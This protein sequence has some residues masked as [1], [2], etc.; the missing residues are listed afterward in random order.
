MKNI[1][2]LNDTQY[3]AL[4]ERAFQGTEIEIGELIRKTTSFSRLEY[5]EKRLLSAIQNIE[6]RFEKEK[7]N[8][9]SDALM[10]NKWYLNMVLKKKQ[11]IMNTV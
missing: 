11:N 8:D 9:V 1:S 5:L 3:K 7:N 2:F 6:N 10:L 4:V